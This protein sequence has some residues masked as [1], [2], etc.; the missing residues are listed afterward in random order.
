MFKALWLM[1]SAR[2]KAAT[3]GCWGKGPDCPPPQKL[4]IMIEP[5]NTIWVKQ[6][7]WEAPKRGL[8]SCFHWKESTKI[9]DV[10]RK[11]MHRTAL[12]TTL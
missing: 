8:R 11:F 9:L 3:Y 7:N 10:S 6:I 1:A 5:A 2:D 12:Y 4:E